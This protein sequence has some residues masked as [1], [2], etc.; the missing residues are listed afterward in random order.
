MHQKPGLLYLLPLLLLFGGC[1]SVQYSAM[2]KVGV[3]KR[4]I[5][6]DRVED[7]QEAHH[8]TLGQPQVPPVGRE[9]RAPR[10]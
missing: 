3:Y 4:D 1:S 2:E 10:G 5:L 9:H 6:V 7:A 8:R